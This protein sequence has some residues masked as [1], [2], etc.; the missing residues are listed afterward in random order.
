MDFWLYS[1]SELRKL[2]SAFGHPRVSA[3][4]NLLKRANP[5]NFDQ[6]V[7][8]ELETFSRECK[9]CTKYSG[10]LRRFKLS[11]GNEDLKLNHTVSLEFIYIFGKP[12]IHIVDEETHFTTKN[13]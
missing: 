13:F 8:E 5:E 9:I 4:H 12:F 11:V 2:H 10:N 6:A 7:R 1:Y 3:R